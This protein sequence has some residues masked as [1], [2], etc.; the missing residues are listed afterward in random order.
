MSN[1]L[2]KFWLNKSK[3]LFFSICYLKNEQMAHSL[4]F[5][6]R[7]EWIAQVAHQKWAMW[8]NRS[9][10]SPK[11]S[12]M[13]VSLRSL[14]GNEGWWANR[15]GRSPKMSKW[16]NGSFFWAN[17][18]FVHFWAKNKRFAVKT[19]ERIPSPDLLP[20]SGQYFNKNLRR[21]GKNLFV[22]FSFGCR[23]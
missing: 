10:R 4:F 13:S 5:G 21:D 14:R 12:A 11:M 7:C 20:P 15:S 9:G 16:V 19:N 17:R 1:S 6:E 3:N 18:S 8:A 22:K 23:N 2:K